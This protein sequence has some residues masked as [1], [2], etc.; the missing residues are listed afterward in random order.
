[1]LDRR[2]S[3]ARLVGVTKLFILVHHRDGAR[4]AERQRINYHYLFRTSRVAAGK[5]QTG[6]YANTAFEPATAADNRRRPSLRSI[7]RRQRLGGGARR[8]VR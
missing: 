6:N 4:F 3:H 8:Q 1:M 2:R 5:L 7:R